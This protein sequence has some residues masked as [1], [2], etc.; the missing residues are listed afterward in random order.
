MFEIPWF[1][2]EEIIATV[3]QLLPHTLDC[4]FK[5]HFLRSLAISWA[6][7]DSEGL[8]AFSLKAS[9]LLT[10]LVR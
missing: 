5:M 7:V 1:F 8:Q 2:D 6:A 4:C 3:D 9:P 10:V